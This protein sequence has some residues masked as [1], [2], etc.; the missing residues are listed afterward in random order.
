LPHIQI[1]ATLSEYSDNTEAS[2]N[3]QVY[4]VKIDIWASNNPKI[5]PDKSF[6]VPIT[7]RKEI[8]PIL[9]FGEVEILIET[10]M[11]YLGLILDKH[12]TWSPLLKPTRKKLNCRLHLLHPILKLNFSLNNKII[13]YKFM[14][15][16][17]LALRIQIWGCVKAFQT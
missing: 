5:N 12:L 3:L 15:K 16:L 7:F 13:I 9:Y 17:I 10:Q 8:S 14:I 1:T 6:H 11:K 4:L 2:F